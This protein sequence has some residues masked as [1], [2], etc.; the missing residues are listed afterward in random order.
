MVRQKP[1]RQSRDRDPQSEHLALS[2]AASGSDDGGGAR[3]SEP[4]RSQVLLQAADPSLDHRGFDRA[5]LSLA[6]AGNG[7]E[8]QPQLGGFPCGLGEGLGLEP[9]FGEVGERDL[10]GLWVV[11]LLRVGYHQ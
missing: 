4:G 8:S 5:Q 7:V 1:M 2:E 9:A 6:E 10:A 3:R 11:F